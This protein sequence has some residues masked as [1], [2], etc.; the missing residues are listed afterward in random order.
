MSVPRSNCTMRSTSPASSIA[1]DGLCGVLVISMR[2]RG[3]TA[4]ATASQSGA[5]VSGS[6]G[7]CTGTPPASTIAGS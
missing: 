6:S 1:P 5:N 2:V 3:V 4:A 7:T